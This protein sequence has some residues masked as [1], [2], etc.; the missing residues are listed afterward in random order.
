MPVCLTVFADASFDHKSGIATFAGWFRTADSI[1]RI[2][3]VSERRFRS[4]NEAELAAL[5]A[6]VLVALGRQRSFGEGD[7][8]V[9]KS[10]C[11][12][13][14]EQLKNSTGGTTETERRLV[15]RV[16]DILKTRGLRFYVR[17]VKGHT[18]LTEPRFYVNRWCDEEAR[19]LL[20]E[21]VRQDKSKRLEK[22]QRKI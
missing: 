15:T 21:A 10:D 13:A 1:H 9:A 17:H 22:K 18:T 14:V 12:Y 3:K 20:R 8:V 2:S 6:T 11:T 5:C 4:S 16:H 7:F 19:R